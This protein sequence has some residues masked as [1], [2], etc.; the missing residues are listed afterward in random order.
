M[1]AAHGFTLLPLDT[2]TAEQAA[3]L[4][5]LQADA[6]DRAPVAVAQRTGALTSNAML[7]RYG[8]PVRW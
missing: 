5:P 8:V 1:L 7:A 3:D 4:P 2:A 6:F